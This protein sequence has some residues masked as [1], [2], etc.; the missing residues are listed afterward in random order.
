MIR[1]HKI[2]DLLTFV[3]RLSNDDFMQICKSKSNGGFVNY[4]KI[5]YPYNKELI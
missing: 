4:T 2:L 5:A 3:K 1:Y